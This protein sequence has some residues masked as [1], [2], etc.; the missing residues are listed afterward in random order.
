M[1]PVG[2]SG[3]L[4]VSRT[5][6]W[7]GSPDGERSTSV[8]VTMQPPIPSP[9]ASPPRRLLSL[10]AAVVLVAGCGL[11]GAPSPTPGPSGPPNPSPPVPGSVVFRATLVQALPPIVQFGWLP[12]VV[13]TAEGSLLQPGPLMELHPGPLVPPVEERAITSR[14]IEILVGAARDAGLLT[15]QVD[16]T[17]GSLRPGQAAGRL[18]I[19]ADGQ[20]YEI[21]GDP[22][23]V[24]RCGDPPARC[25]PAPGSP[26]AFAHF[27]LRLS[28]LPG[29]LGS[30][31]GSP[32]P[33]VPAAY[34]ILVGPPPSEPGLAPAPATWP[35]EPRLRDFGAG[36]AGDP[37]RRCGVVAGEAAATLRPILEAANELTPWIDPDEPGQ[38]YGLTVRPLL[39]GDPDPCAVLVGS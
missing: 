15:G 36:L 28:D 32:R 17:G 26:E 37:G 4:W 34:A 24:V 18:E 19:V 16:F 14:G 33:H 21:V 25:I 5:V 12:V 2:P 29:W 6:L 11:G 1:V 8:V 38:R 35:L 3:N 39:P 9:A 13:V 27:W 10:L 20:R 30:E 31:L 23:R 7:A 22:S